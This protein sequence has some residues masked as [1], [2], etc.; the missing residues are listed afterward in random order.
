MIELTA[1]HVLLVRLGFHAV[2]SGLKK[3]VFFG[4]GHKNPKAIGC[5]D[6]LLCDWVVKIHLKRREHVLA[7]ENG[8]E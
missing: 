5:L 6:R 4:F 2:G 7:G 8:L 1:K 3:V